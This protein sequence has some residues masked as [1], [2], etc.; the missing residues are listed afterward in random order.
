M[1]MGNKLFVAIAVLLAACTDSGFATAKLAE[2]CEYFDD[3]GA[4][5]TRAGVSSLLKELP[6][7]SA[8]V[9]CQTSRSVDGI[10]VLGP[11]H[12]RDGVSYFGSIYFEIPVSEHDNEINLVEF[13]A[14]HEPI[15]R[16][17][18]MAL[19]VGPKISHH[20]SGFVETNSISVGTFKNLYNLW[21]SV[22][23]APKSRFRYLNTARLDDDSAVVFSEFI[24]SLNVDRSAKI[25][26][27][28]FSG[29]DP[30]DPSPSFTV[31]I[32]ESARSWSIEFDVLDSKKVVLL[33]VV[34][35]VE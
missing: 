14:D 22:I 4:S 33:S 30:L 24:R 13:T 20:E 21:V 32:S 5:N 34:K 18:M 6:E 8:I 9:V 19:G 28:F 7:S 26:S 31:E 23:A 1:R 15:F 12:N 25:R 11:I 3:S 17:T 16:N 35:L 27:L 2:N 29:D 10:F